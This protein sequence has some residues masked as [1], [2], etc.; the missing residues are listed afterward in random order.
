MGEL[1]RAGGWSMWF[2]LLNGG[3]ALVAAAVFV[4]KA[5][6]R[7]LALVRALTWS[8]VFSV[9][10]GLCANFVAVMWH[11]SRREELAHA[12]DLHL[13]VMEGLGEAVTPGILGFAML[14]LVWLMVAVGTRRVQD[15]E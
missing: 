10:S 15:A 13:T 2:V 12:P 5:D 9:L 4:W 6:L 3:A 1:I 14:S 8:T 7:R 11:C